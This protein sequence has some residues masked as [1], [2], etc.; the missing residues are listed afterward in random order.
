VVLDS[1]SARRKGAIP[2]LSIVEGFMLSLTGASEGRL[3]AAS[4]SGVHFVCIDGRIS[5][6]LTRA[7]EKLD[8]ELKYQQ[9]NPS[10]HFMEIIEAARSVILAGGT[11]SPVR[12]PCPTSM[13]SDPI[14]LQDLRC[15]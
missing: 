6:S 8:V 3:S 1:Q 9:L 7:A 10:P 2:P 14:F 12:F 11:M 4:R 15:N 13:Q 5:I